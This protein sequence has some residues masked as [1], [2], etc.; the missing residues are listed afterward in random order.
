[1][2]GLIVTDSLLC[3]ESAR[4]SPVQSSLVRYRVGNQVST[5][6]NSQS[7]PRSTSRSS[8]E[9]EV[10]GVTKEKVEEWGDERRLE[11]QC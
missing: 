11:S 8:R 6:T 2:G 5:I 1:M 7:G 9:S 4:D 3:T 10:C